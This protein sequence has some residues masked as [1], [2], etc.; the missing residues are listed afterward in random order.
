MPE[1]CDGIDNNCDGNI[2]EGVTTRYFE[3]QDQDGFGNND[4]VEEACNQPPGFVTIGSDCDDENDENFSSASEV[5]NE[6][7]DDCDGEIDEDL[8]FG[9]LQMR[10]VMDTATKHSPSDCMNEGYVF[11]DDWMIPTQMYTHIM[12][13]SVMVSQDRDGR[14]DE[15][16]N[17]TYYADADADGRGDDNTMVQTCVVPAGYVQMGGDCDDTTNGTSK[18]IGVQLN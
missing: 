11:N 3:D 9:Y 18:C 10:T 16:G 4:Q 6:V 13:N 7:D 14:I 2:D 17:L 12:M 15:T 1:I 5:C 8:A